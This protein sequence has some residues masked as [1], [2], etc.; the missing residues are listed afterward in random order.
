MALAGGGTDLEPYYSRYG[1]FVLNATIDQY[2]YCKVEPNREWCFKSIDL[3]I[4]EKHN[5]WNNAEYIVRM[6]TDLIPLSEI[7]LKDLEADAPLNQDGFVAGPDRP[8]SDWFFIVPVQHIK[9][10]EELAMGPQFNGSL[11]HTHTFIQNIGSPYR[12]EH[13][14]FNIRTP[15]ARGVELDRENYHVFAPQN[16]ID[17]YTIIKR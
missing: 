3:G 17:G 11:M 16:Q 15:T 10:L 8:W 12:I 14:N 7:E 6:R 1:G 5:L 13:H 4:E 2:A 9:F